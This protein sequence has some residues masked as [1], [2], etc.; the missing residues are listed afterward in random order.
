MSVDTEGAAGTLMSELDAIEAELMLPGEHK[1]TFGLNE[2]SR[3]NE[4]LAS[5]ISVIA[6]ADTKPTTKSLQVAEMYSDQIEEQLGRLKEVLEGDLVGFNALM[7]RTDLPAV[8][9]EV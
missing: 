4:K 8:E 2:R 6:S 9:Q 7:K 5:V 3:L 1:D